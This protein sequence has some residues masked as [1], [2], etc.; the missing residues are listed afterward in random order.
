MVENNNNTYFL[1]KFQQ[2]YSYRRDVHSYPNTKNRFVS[3]KLKI[4]PISM[5]QG[6]SWEDFRRSAGQ[7][8]SCLLWNPKFHYHI[9]KSLPVVPNLSQPFK[10]ETLCNIP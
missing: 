2:T 1:F 10:S 7:E 4:S 6:P 3:R 9:H 8:I 5:E